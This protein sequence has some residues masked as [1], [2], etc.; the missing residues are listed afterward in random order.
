MH[1]ARVDQAV[2]VRRRPPRPLLVTTPALARVP[3]QLRIDHSTCQLC[4]RYQFHVEASESYFQQTAS[5]SGEKEEQAPVRD[6]LVATG[7][8]KHSLTTSCSPGIAHLISHGGTVHEAASMVYRGG[9]RPSAVHRVTQSDYYMLN[10]A[11]TSRLYQFE[12]NGHPRG[13]THDAHERSVR[14]L[15]Q[16]FHFSGCFR[17]IRTTGV[18]HVRDL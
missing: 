16:T 8:S 6:G 12:M 11:V 5:R 14:P 17:F 7:V 10:N 3:K 9:S 13:I 2:A 4:G 18:W 15:P 1:D